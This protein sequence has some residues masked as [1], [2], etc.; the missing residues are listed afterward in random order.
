M[1]AESAMV[2]NSGTFF[3]HNKE[4]VIFE[5]QRPGS[6]HFHYVG[7]EKDEYWRPDIQKVL[8]G[9][10]EQNFW[11]AVWY[12][13]VRHGEAGDQC[14]YYPLPLIFSGKAERESSAKKENRRPPNER[15]VRRTQRRILEE[16]GL[17]K[18]D[19]GE[20]IQVECD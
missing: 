14:G 6:D 17:N 19:L 8:K 5:C 20:F 16:F 18:E 11:G 7:V 1:K 9:E 4:G 3:E 12:L 2:K 15:W 13:L 10:I